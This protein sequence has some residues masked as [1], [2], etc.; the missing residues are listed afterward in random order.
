MKCCLIGDFGV[1]KTTLVRKLLKKSVQNIQSTIGIDF[2][3]MMLSLPSGIVKA[4][5]WDTAGAERFRSLMS[6]YIRDAKIIF[7]VY[8]VSKKDVRSQI[9][10][11]IHIIEQQASDPRPAVICVYGNKLDLCVTGPEE[12][13]HIIEP[14]VRQGWYITTSYGSA[15][16]STNFKTQ[17]KMC[18][19]RVVEKGQTNETYVPEQIYFR[20]PT[21][22]QRLCCS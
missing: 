3:S 4:T 12:I 20:S 6:H 1:G 14:W 15:I 7:I 8:D 13:D 18:L 16:K 19:N 21:P 22:E 11:W 17:L 9:E 5:L 10:P 2:F